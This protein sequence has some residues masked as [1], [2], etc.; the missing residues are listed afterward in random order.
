MEQVQKSVFQKIVVE[1]VVLK[2]EKLNYWIVQK[3]LRVVSVLS[4]R[5]GRLYRGWGMFI[6]Y[7]L[8]L[9][10]IYILVLNRRQIGLIVKY[11]VLRWFESRIYLWFRT[12][13]TIC[14]YTIYKV[15]F[16]I[17]FISKWGGSNLAVLIAVP[18]FCGL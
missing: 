13:F 4:L 5:L 11:N 10:R 8:S 17:C 3:K 9:G 6:L 12:C 18:S 14:I 15:V 2:D 16:G 1:R 7:Y